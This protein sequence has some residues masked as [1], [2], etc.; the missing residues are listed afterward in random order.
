[1]PSNANTSG[2]QPALLFIP[3]ISGFTKF[4]IDTEIS[5][6]QHIIQELLE[7]IIDANQIGL[8][9]SEIEGDAI[10][11]YRFGPAPTAIEMLNQVREMFVRFHQHLR[12]YDRF[13]ICNCG[14]CKTANDLTLKFIAHYGDITENKIKDHIKLFG[15]EVIVVH[16]LLKNDIEHHEYA[17]LTQPLLTAT[18]SEYQGRELW[19]PLQGGSQEYDSGLIEFQYLAL[20]PLSEQVPE[21]L[22]E[23]YSIP[24][25]K[26]QVLHA[27]TLIEAPLDMVFGVFADL[28]WRAKWVVG[29]EAGVENIKEDIFQ[30]GSSHRCIAGGPSLVTH[31]FKR[32]E[33]AVA[34]T[35][36]DDDRSQCTVYTLRRKSPV[37]TQLEADYF[38]KRNPIK[39]FLFRLFGKN[40]KESYLT[41][42][43]QNLNGYCKLLRSEGKAHPESVKL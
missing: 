17:M 21:P 32:S 22:A 28:P 12:K 35:E 13:R 40:K 15:K 9:I 25:A 29:Q 1:M 2:V 36:T 37:E 3:D 39:V 30:V 10:L 11:F 26:E 43:M 31:D 6:S 27:E 23:D 5:H 20:A 42:T 8:E 18:V 34:F 41:Q 16:R 4:I 24:G 38:L 7:I 33:E 14:A 19:A